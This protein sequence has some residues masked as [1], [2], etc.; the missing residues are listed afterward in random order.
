M[1]ALNSRESCLNNMA[2]TKTEL[3][4]KCGHKITMPGL[5]LL[6]HMTCKKCDRIKKV[7]KR[8]FI[9]G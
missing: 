5:I 4:L 8:M 9:E 6:T 2:V 7:T 3:T 1:H